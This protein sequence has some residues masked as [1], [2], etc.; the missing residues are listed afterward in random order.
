[1][2]K[3]PKLRKSRFLYATTVLAAA[4]FV[5]SCAATS[6]PPVY[7]GPASSAVGADNTSIAHGSMVKKYHNAKELA[8]DASLLV[9]GI[10]TGVEEATIADLLFAR[11]TIEVESK[12]AGEADDEIAVYMVGEPGMQFQFDSP[13]YFNDGQRYVLFL[14]PT[15]VTDTQGREGYYVVGPGAWGETSAAGFTIWVDP[16]ADIDIANIPSSF[17][18]DEVAKVLSVDRLGASD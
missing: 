3:T 15:D 6:G 9:V 10:M 17:S 8:E 16:K 7:R 4:A 18:L 13:A 14:R 11:Y 12:L 2:S 1:M 5:A